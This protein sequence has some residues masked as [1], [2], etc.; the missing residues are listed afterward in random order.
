MEL[1]LGAILF[2]N[3][4]L[5]IGSA[6]LAVPVLIHLLTRR[7][8]R[9]MVFPTLQFIRSAKANQSSVHRLRHILLLLVR[10][11]LVLFI[12][13]AF[14]KPMLMRGAGFGSK[15]DKAGKSTVILMDASASMGYSAGAVTSLSKA[16]VAALEILEHHSAEDHVN[17]ILMGAVPQGSFDS[18][19]GNLFPL[20]KDVR[21]ASLTAEHADINA[22]L[23]EAVR[24]LDSG[25]AGRKE[26]YLVSDFQR[27]NW[28]SVNFGIVSRN[29]ELIF[30]PVG[31]DQA[32][33]TSITSVAVLP[34]SPTVAE[35]VEIV[36]KVANYGDSSCE[37]PLELVF[38][39]GEV[40]SRRVS[41]GPRMTA[42]ASFRVR[43]NKSGRYEGKLSIPDDGLDVD[44]RRFFTFDVTQA[45]NILLVS[46]DAS[47]KAKSGSLFLNRA[48]NPFRQVQDATAVASVVRSDQLSTLNVAGAQVVMLCGI[49]ELPRSAAEVLI[50]YLRDGGSVVYFHVGG[51]DAHNLKLLADISEGDFVAPY[52]MT[53]QVD[54]SLKGNYTTLAEANFDHRL[55]S[56]FKES[57]ELSDLKFYGYFSTERVKQ[58]GRILL[59]YEDRNIAMAEK[60]VGSGTILL[61]N[62]GCSLEHSDI[63]RH[64]LFVPLVHEIIKSLRPSAGARNSFEVGDQCSMT[65]SAVARSDEVEFRSPAD[66]VIDGNIEVGISGAAV[67]FPQT[68]QCGFYRIYAGG[69]SV[70]SVAVNVN[71]LEG[72][73]ETLAVPQL[74]ELAQVPGSNFHA[75]AGSQAGINA[76]LAGRPIWHYFLLGAIGLLAFEQVL[77]SIWKR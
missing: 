35:T 1:L 56:K 39:D 40:L 4:A 10:T 70:G 60:T 76:L 18:L 71:P 69:E 6:A 14:L 11:A 5:W 25:P 21:D 22:A 67:F 27:S 61:C 68:K 2:S 51:A 58:K 55:L 36:C 72:N 46:D 33:N 17:L 23:A 41:L 9:D 74:R 15:D 53:G 65:T 7:T 12:L 43:I 77:V 63:A 8:P 47:G 26:I 29:I 48:V 57:G 50:N 16:K 3:P 19:S 52:T 37:V 28:S 42:A 31:P 54:L 64:T 30:I 24:Q 66:E 34:A 38:D 73:L 32:E 49:N 75:A 13:F 45:I 62:F 44:N 59:R 20:R